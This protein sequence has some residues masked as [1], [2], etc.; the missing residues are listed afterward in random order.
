LS[1]SS[2]V[3]KVTNDPLTGKVWFKNGDLIDAETQDLK[4]ETAFRKILSWKTG[5]FEILPAEPER[6]RTIFNSYQGLLL[7]S[8][9]ALDEAKGQPPGGGGA[10]GA[11]AESPLAQ[12]ARFNGVEFVLSVSGDDQKFESWSAENPEQISQWVRQTNQ[13][14]RALGE[15]F[16]AGQL[17]QVEGLGPQCHV[18]LVS[19]ENTDLCVGFHR[20]LS[21]DLVRDT[22]RKIVI[23]WAS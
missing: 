5:N 20:S 3:L 9:Q 14:F 22:M 17:N 4:G 21:Q 10:G 2:S 12:L 19:R 23:Q 1:Q 7:E 11:G 13:R 16:Q 8:A 18:A 6:N 15:N